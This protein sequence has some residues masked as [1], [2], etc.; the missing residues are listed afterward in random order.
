MIA[1]LQRVA[2]ASVSV[3]NETVAAIGAGLLVYVASAAAGR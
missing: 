3:E 2:S 1:L